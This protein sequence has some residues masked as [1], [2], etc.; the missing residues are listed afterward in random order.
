[1]SFGK[2]LAIMMVMFGGCVLFGGCM[3]IGGYNSAVGF[4]EKVQSTWAEVENQLQRRFDLI[5]NVVETVKGMAAQEEKIFIGVAEARKAYFQAGTIAEKASAATAVHTALMPMMRLQETYPALKSNEGFM[6]LQDSLEGTENRV[7][8]ARGRYNE[9]VSAL[10]TFVR[11]F[12]GRL[13]ASWAGVEKAEYFAV[14]E[15]A[16]ATP[17]VSFTGGDG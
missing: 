2:V 8:V 11:K 9:S 14:A 5:P 13:Y 1:M 3:V 15:E 10:N 12:T 17:K 7:A 16:K 6:R 4:D